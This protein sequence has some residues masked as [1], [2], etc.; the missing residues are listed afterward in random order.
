MVVIQVE[1]QVLV[2]VR[3]VTDR[4]SKRV[5][6]NQRRL[7]AVLLTP[8]FSSCP[9]PYALYASKVA[10]LSRRS[11][12]NHPIRKHSNIRYAFTS[13]NIVPKFRPISSGTPS[14]DGDFNVRFQGTDSLSGET[15][16]ARY[17][18]HCNPVDDLY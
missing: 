18:K 15:G 2:R 10:H 7:R 9:Y 11:R 17:R 16:K 3:P 13:D 4:T 12:R 1:L 14:R 5:Y 8:S 6:R